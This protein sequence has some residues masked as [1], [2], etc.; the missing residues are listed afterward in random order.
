MLKILSLYYKSYNLGGLL[1]SYALC[2]HISNNN[3]WIAEQMLLEI[4]IKGTHRCICTLHLPIKKIYHIIYLKCLKILNIFIYKNKKRRKIILDFREQVVP[5]G[6]IYNALNISTS[7]SNNDIF[8][9]GSDQI[10]NPAWTEDAYFLNFV[11]DNNG[12]IAYAASIGA[13]EVPQDFLEHVV[14]Y[15]RRFDF[16]SVRE[17]SAKEILQPYLDQEIKVTLDPT[18]LLPQEEWDKIAVQ[19]MIPQ[20]YIFVYLLG[21]KRAHR[22]LIKKFARTLGLKIAFLPHVHFHFNP[23]DCFFAD[24]NLYDVGPAEFVGL[25]KNAEIVI[26]DSFHGCVFSIIYGRKFWALKR[27]KDSDPQNMNSRLYTL[28]DSLGLGDRLIENE[29]AC[30]DANF[31]DKPIDYDGVTAKLN[32]QR[33]ESA[34][35]L[36]NAIKTVQT[37][38]RKEN[39]YTE[40]NPDE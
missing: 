2:R 21:E 6:G 25:V 23:A 36:L 34:D 37:R 8:I 5:H 19:P 22:R 10:W 20:P 15:L 24:Y 14:P 11:P 29:D 39:Q 3:D 26:T 4:Y 31:L 30:Y 27:H 9:A 1:Q 32:A 35:F 33:K 16:I 40:E 13:N 12:K 38:M 7:I 28:F 17:E 18:L